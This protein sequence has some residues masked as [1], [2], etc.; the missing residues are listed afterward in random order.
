MLAVLF[1]ATF[2]TVTAEMLPSG[3]LPVL[4]RDLAVSSG[5]VGALVSGWA[6]TVAVVGIPLVRMTMK[7]PAT[8]LLAATLAVLAVANLVTAFAPDFAVALAG[9]VLAA[10]AHGLFWAR[11]VA[12]V[13]AAVEP[14]KLGRALAIVLSG[15]TVAGL[16][17]L[18]AATFVAGHTG[19]R[20][21]FA[22]LSV[23]FLLTGLVLWLVL[24]RRPAP[25]AAPQPAGTRDH[26][27]RRVLRVAIAGSLVLVGHF[28]V[29]TYVA[30][31]VTGLGGFTTADV[32]VLL[33][34]FGV[35]GGLGTLVSGTATDRFPTAAVA[36]AAALVVFGLALLALGGDRPVLFTAGVAVWGL[37]IG[38]F[39][40]IL[41]ARVLRVSTPA[42]RPLAGGIV[43]T[44][45]NLG[46]AAGAAVGGIIL[47][48]GQTTLTVVAMA[49]AAAGTLALAVHGRR[50]E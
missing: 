1:A 10:A 28:A 50:A 30:A 38:A 46:I 29:F 16:A 41:Q 43:I 42:F 32:P 8:V 26:S 39:P 33:L 11:V 35:A 6:I 25:Q 19:W 20:A 17:G 7:I 47:S 13:A 9:R 23:L 40:P 48:H 24:A 12:Y 15:P 34:V 22:G 36:A 37:A 14:A 27:A 4:S 18:P 21:V 49:A 3:L 44:V 31:L 5:A 2:V 45:L